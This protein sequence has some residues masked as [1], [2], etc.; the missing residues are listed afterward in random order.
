MLRPAR[1]AGEER[2]QLISRFLRNSQFNWLLHG[3]ALHA[4][5]SGHAS[6][7][8][9]FMS[10]P[11]SPA[12]QLRVYSESADRAVAF[13]RQQRF[14]IGRPHTFDEKY[15]GVTALETFAGALVADIIN[16]LLLRARQRRLEIERIEGVV[17]IWL[18]NALTFLEVVGEEGEPS[19]ESVAVQLYVSTLETEAAVG[20][21]MRETLA[22]SPLYLT[23][24]KA[25]AVT[26]N[27]QVA[28]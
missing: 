27:F 10:D 2:R 6:A 11:A 15:E 3:I 7:T 17:K 21:L 4:M 8:R 16:G 12:C 28:I 5:T 24:C 25:A 14:E 18:G 20:T 1:R 19:I 22:R 13:A 26:V 9:P 23:L